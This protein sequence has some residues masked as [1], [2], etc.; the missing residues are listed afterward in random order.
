MTT[1][2]TATAQITQTLNSLASGDLSKAV[3][4]IGDARVTVERNPNNTIS[5]LTSDYSSIVTNTLVCGKHL[6]AMDSDDMVRLTI[7]STTVYFVVNA[8]HHISMTTE[9]TIVKTVR[10]PMEDE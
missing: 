8:D 9:E 10:F 6:E 1:N 5:V 4:T 2:T 7:D 3:I